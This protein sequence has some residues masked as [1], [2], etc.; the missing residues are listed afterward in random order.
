MWSLFGELL[1][2]S[3]IEHPLPY[4]WRIILDNDSK[5][6]IKLLNSLRIL[7]EIGKRYPNFKVQEFAKN[8]IEDQ[9]PKRE[10]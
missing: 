8:S 5:R 3:N 10:P 6:K 9:N 2:V 1:C 4:R 7:K